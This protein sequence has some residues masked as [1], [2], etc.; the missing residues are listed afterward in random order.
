MWNDYPSFLIVLVL[1]LVAIQGS[2]RLHCFCWFTF[3]LV[4]VCHWHWLIDWLYCYRHNGSKRFPRWGSD[5]EEVAASKADSVVCSVYSGWTNLHRHWTN[6]AWQST[7]IPAGSVNTALDFSASQFFQSY[8]DQVRFP[9]MI[10]L[11]IRPMWPINFCCLLLDF[12]MN[13]F[14]HQLLG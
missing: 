6:E 9:K 3:M 2:L 13:V 4:I 5:N 11:L 8:L 7:W 10:S 12:K 14:S 1:L